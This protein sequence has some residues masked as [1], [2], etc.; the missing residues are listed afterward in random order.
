M[1]E[2]LIDYLFETS[3]KEGFKK[4]REDFVKYLQ[5]DDELFDYLYGKAQKEGYKKDKS[6]FAGLVGRT[7]TA[8]PV[9]TTEPAK[10]EVVTEPAKT[11]VVTEPAKTEPAP[12]KTEVSIATPVAETKPTIEVKSVEPTPT[13]EEPMTAEKKEVVK[14][15][16]ESQLLPVTEKTEVKAIET[17]SDKMVVKSKKKEAEKDEW[18][19]PP[20]EKGCS[21]NEDAVSKYIDKTY[22]KNKKDYAF[23]ADR[24]G[25]LASFIDDGGRGK[26]MSEVYKDENYNHDKKGFM[27][28]A[29]ELPKSKRFSTYSLPINGVETSIVYDNKTGIILKDTGD[30]ITNKQG[31]PIKTWLDVP[32][33]NPEYE[34]LKAEIGKAKGGNTAPKVSTVP[35]L[36]PW[37]QPQGTKVE[38]KEVPA[39][40]DKMVIKSE[41]KVEPKPIEEV[42][43]QKVTFSKPIIINGAKFDDDMNLMRTFSP[44]SFEE[45]KELSKLA[46]PVD[47]S[48]DEIAQSFGKYFESIELDRNIS[49]SFPDPPNVKKKSVVT[50]NTE[51]IFEDKID[52][53]NVYYYYDQKNDKWYIYNKERDENNWNEVTSP[54]IK[55]V[56]NTKYKNNSGEID[57]SK[58]F[59]TEESEGKKIERIKEY[60]YYNKYLPTLIENWDNL[61][62]NQKENIKK[63]LNILLMKRLSRDMYWQEKNKEEINDVKERIKR[64][65]TVD[66]ID[67]N[68]L[69]YGNPDERY[70]KFWEVVVEKTGAG[71]EQVKALIKK[72]KK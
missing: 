59:K 71:D 17:P 54:Q 40:S 35:T 28:A 15:D 65:E 16:I 4:N 44:S 18:E 38:V 55:T 58:I 69:K 60:Y 22:H 5:S 67:M 47:K 31:D 14:S 53:K 49:L 64:N 6:H 48:L 56:L 9:A 8:A 37:Q 30:V 62:E 11:E 46:K 34:A 26:S 36:E 66:E 68:L 42:N 61:K 41:A 3:R 45:Y 29:E 25:N 70:D 2:E 1:D 33:N 72:Y 50:Q 12:V 32:M 19:C 24:E 57:K 10:T 43:Q 13:K 52:N 23:I 7:S 27:Y 21:K 39:V 63:D 20:G 51:N